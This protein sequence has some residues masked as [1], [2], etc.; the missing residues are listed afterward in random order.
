MLGESSRTQ[1]SDG[2][3][4]S[5][6]IF[7]GGS[8]LDVSAVNTTYDI[9]EIGNSMKRCFDS[10]CLTLLLEVNVS[11]HQSGEHSSYSVDGST[12][13]RP[14]GTKQITKDQLKTAAREEMQ[15]YKNLESCCDLLRLLMSM[16]SSTKSTRSTIPWQR[17]WYMSNDIVVQIERM[18]RLSKHSLP[19]QSASCCIIWSM[20]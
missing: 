13:C 4:G 1:I 7:V 8:E 17:N 2:H 14:T 19:P 18:I 3:R 12:H 20:N 5:R 15:C 10:S 9:W 11:R 6:P 16:L